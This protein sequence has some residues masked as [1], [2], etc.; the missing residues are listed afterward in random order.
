MTVYAVLVEYFG[1]FSI[2]SH[3]EKVIFSNKDDLIEYVLE[4]EVSSCEDWQGKTQID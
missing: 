2:D 1:P 3:Y 4:Y